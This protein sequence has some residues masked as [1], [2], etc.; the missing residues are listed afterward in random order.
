M[1]TLLTI[2]HDPDGKLLKPLQKALPLF[3]DLFSERY[4]VIT[5]ETHSSYY[6]MYFLTHFRPRLGM[7]EA[8]RDVI[9]FALEK[10]IDDYYFYCDL[11]RLIHWATIHPDELRETISQAQS[12]DYTVIGRTDLAFASHPLFQM[13]TERMMNLLVNEV[14]KMG[15]DFFAGARCFSH[16]AAKWISEK[17]IANHAAQDIEWPL[18]VKDKG[19]TIGYVE[20]DGLAY[21][22]A[23]LDIRHSRED[24]IKLRMTNLKS[25]LEFLE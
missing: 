12:K 8:R 17:S 4:L 25:V 22:S 20:A 9:K 19:G 11:D 7:A 18:I 23:A 3:D 13:E 5:T 16:R 6:G 21:E 10:T 1:V 15:M 14:Y 24:E 2:Q